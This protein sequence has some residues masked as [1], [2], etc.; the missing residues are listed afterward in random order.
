MFIMLSASKLSPEQQS[1]PDR[2]VF[3]FVD[4]EDNDG[5][6]S[7][8]VQLLDASPNPFPEGPIKLENGKMQ[9]FSLPMQ[10]GNVLRDKSAEPDGYRFHDAFHIGL[11][12][13]IGWSPVM[14]N[15]LNLRRRSNPDID[16]FEDGGRAIVAE[17]SFVNTL[18]VHDVDD[19]MHPKAMSELSFAVDT[20]QAHWERAG[21]NNS[22]LIKRPEALEVVEAALFGRFLLGMVDGY[23]SERGR[24]TVN[25]DMSERKATISDSDIDIHDVWIYKWQSIASYYEFMAS[26]KTPDSL[27]RWGEENSARANA[28]IKNYI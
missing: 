3:E 23:V 7:C 25:V 18:N 15:N 6:N 14:R 11:M 26:E 19:G 27:R 17:E 28:F 21:L 2:M 12:T 20:L 13:K 5:I 1:F 4:R 9:G 16:E 8:R 22:E 24:A 10:I